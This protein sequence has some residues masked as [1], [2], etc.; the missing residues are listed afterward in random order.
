MSL[1]GN[2]DLTFDRLQSIKFYFIFLKDHLSRH[3]EFEGS[4]MLI[5]LTIS[6]YIFH[7]MLVLQTC[8]WKSYRLMEA[9]SEI[10]EG[11]LIMHQHPC[12]QSERV[13]HETVVDS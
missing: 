12:W 9:S 6:F 3:S 13:M 10:S 4:Q 7:R 1:R 8:R 11:G 5:E 2:S